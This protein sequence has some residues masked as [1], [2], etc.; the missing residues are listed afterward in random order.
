MPSLRI[1]MISMDAHA[2]D[3]HGGTGLPAGGAAGR[4]AGGQISSKERH[5]CVRYFNGFHESAGLF[6]AHRLSHGGA[7]VPL[8]PVSDI[9][10]SRL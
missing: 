1:K 4:Q 6:A 8:L 9:G 3:C 7:G 5:H 2:A 10:A